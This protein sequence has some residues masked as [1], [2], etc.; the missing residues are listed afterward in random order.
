MSGDVNVKFI[1]SQVF[2]QFSLSVFF[3][4]VLLEQIILRIYFKSLFYLRKRD[5][6]L[7]NFTFSFVNKDRFLFYD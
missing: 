4:P 5:D 6:F 2:A 3:S 7:V 1:S